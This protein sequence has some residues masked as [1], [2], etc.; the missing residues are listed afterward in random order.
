MMP[1]PRTAPD[2]EA[3]ER[4]TTQSPELSFSPWRK[5]TPLSASGDKPGEFSPLALAKTDPRLSPP[6]ENAGASLAIQRKQ[7]LFVAVCTL[8][9]A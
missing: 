6:G 2:I 5:G 4:P 9:D 7:L 3:D 1:R 8:D